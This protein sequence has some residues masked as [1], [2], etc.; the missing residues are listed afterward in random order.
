MTILKDFYERPRREKK[1]ARRTQRGWVN[2]MP[3]LEGEAPVYRPASPAAREPPERP[4]EVLFIGDWIDMVFLHLEVDPEALQE[5]EPLK[6]D[7]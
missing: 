1:R 2:D 6:L 3:L 5:V 7:C 4:G